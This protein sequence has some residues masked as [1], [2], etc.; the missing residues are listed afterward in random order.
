MFTAY[1][2]P[3]PLLPSIHYDFLRLK[4][5]LDSI[6]SDKAAIPGLNRNVLHG[7]KVLCPPRELRGSFGDFAETLYRQTS[8]LTQQ[9]QKLRAARDL[10]LPRLMNG[11]IAV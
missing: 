1:Q 10:L 9:N 3:L 7:L 4:A 8:T 5:A 6:Q 2:T 11:E